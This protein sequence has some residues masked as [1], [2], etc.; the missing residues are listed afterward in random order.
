MK[1]VALCASVA[2]LMVLSSC[3]G[4]RE[5]PAVEDPYEVPVDT[6]LT[7]LHD[8]VLIGHLGEETGMS[9]LQLVTEACDTFSISKTAIN[10]V[11]GLMLGE[12][13]NFDDKVMVV[14]KM[15]KDEQYH[16]TSFLNISQ[17]EKAWKAQD[18]QLTLHA[19]STVETTGMNYQNWRIERCKLLLIGDSKTEYGTTQTVDTVS[20]EYLDEDS[21]HISSLR[22]GKV[23]FG[24]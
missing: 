9:A 15:D 23:K 18:H 19:D 14:V 16:L 1:R 6:T 8:T 5:K 24:L 11:E 4:H 12:V 20:I 2:G 22:H 17:L 7:V 13:R 10:G 3:L 21:L